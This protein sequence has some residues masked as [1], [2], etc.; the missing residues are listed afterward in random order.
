MTETAIM[1]A[2]ARADVIVCAALRVAR[3]AASIG[4]GMAIGRWMLRR[5]ERRR[6]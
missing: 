6:G 2:V 3:I 5:R 4:L 1:A